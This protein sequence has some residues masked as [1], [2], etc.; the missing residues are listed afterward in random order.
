MRKEKEEAARKRLALIVIDE[1]NKHLRQRMTK[2]KRR[3]WMKDNLQIECDERMKGMEKTKHI[4]KRVRRELRMKVRG[5]L[6]KKENRERNM[7]CGVSFK[8]DSINETQVISLFDRY[9]EKGEMSGGKRVFCFH[10]HVGETQEIVSILNEKRRTPLDSLHDAYRYVY[11]AIRTVKKMLGRKRASPQPNERDER[12]KEKMQLLINAIE[13][14]NIEELR[15]L[16]IKEKKE[17][18]PGESEREGRFLEVPLPAP[19]RGE[20]WNPRRNEE[21]ERQ[22]ADAG[23]WKSEERERPRREKS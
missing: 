2:E 4:P 12:K 21:I 10:E 22:Q 19:R 13:H 23:V 11:A 20:G 7:F 18:N 14:N 5:Y 9:H 3:E 1:V 15:R 16:G 8:E 6:R 17:K